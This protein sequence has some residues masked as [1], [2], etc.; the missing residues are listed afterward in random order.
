[1]HIVQ[2]SIIEI[3]FSIHDSNGCGAMG[4]IILRL[5][6][7]LFKLRHEI[8][9]TTTQRHDTQIGAQNDWAPA[10]RQ[11]IFLI[12]EIYTIHDSSH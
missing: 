11:R 7:K 3:L 2:A 12:L 9:C 10:A 5:S 1:M 4:L 8:R 6:R